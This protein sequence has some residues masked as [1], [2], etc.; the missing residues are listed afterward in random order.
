MARSQE[1]TERY[2]KNST[3]RKRVGTDTTA[4]TSPPIEDGGK[5]DFHH[6]PT[7]AVMGQPA[8]KVDRIL[9]DGDTVRLSDVVLVA[10]HTPGHTRALR[11]RGT[12]RSSTMEGLQGRVG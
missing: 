9:H 5:G 11:R 12:Q 10:H 1:Q 6:G 8:V 3:E 4:R 2:M 7:G